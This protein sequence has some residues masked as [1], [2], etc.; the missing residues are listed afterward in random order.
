MNGIG[1][2][3]YPILHVSKFKINS[4][5]S[6]ITSIYFNIVLNPLDYKNILLL[7]NKKSFSLIQMFKFFN[8]VNC[9]KGEGFIPGPIEQ[10]KKSNYNYSN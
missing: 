1:S 4:S 10:L 7:F 2:T 9:F 5:N 8:F 3:S 6:F